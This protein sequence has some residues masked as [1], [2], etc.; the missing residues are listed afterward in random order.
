MEIIECA[1]CG[2][3]I[4][5]SDAFIDHNFYVCKECYDEILIDELPDSRSLMEFVVTKRICASTRGVQFLCSG[6]PNR[7]EHDKRKFYSTD[8]IFMKNLLPD[9]ERNEADHCIYVG[10]KKRPKTDPRQGIEVDVHI[11]RAPHDGWHEAW[12]FG[13]NRG[14]SRM[15]TPEEPEKVRATE[16]GVKAM[17]S[18][19]AM[20]ISTWCERDYFEYMPSDAVFKVYFK[21][22]RKEAKDGKE[23]ANH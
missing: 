4:A 20:Y 8:G 16:Y 11:S 19:G 14:K 9:L 7:N 2:K 21:V 17:I 6:Y 15:L 13:G 23:K 1:R 5:K 10:E 18:H 12:V 3:E 22:T